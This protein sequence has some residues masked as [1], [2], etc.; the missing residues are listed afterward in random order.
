MH[1]I[2]E[3]AFKSKKELEWAYVINHIIKQARSLK[4]EKLFALLLRENG[5]TSRMCRELLRHKSVY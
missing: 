1:A 3:V 5:L 4:W 2:M